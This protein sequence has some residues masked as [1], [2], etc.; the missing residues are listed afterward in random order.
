MLTNKLGSALF[1]YLQIIVFAFSM[2]L[3][4]LGQVNHD[5]IQLFFSL[6]LLFLANLAYGLEKMRERFVFFL[7]NFACIFFLYG[8]T[9]IRITEQDN[10]QG[11]YSTQAH[12]QTITMIYV[13][14][15]FLLFGAIFFGQFRN[16]KVNIKPVI[17][18]KRI[19]QTEEFIKNLQIITFIV[20][21]VLAVFMLLVEIEKP[22]RL[23]GAAYTEYYY[24]YQSSLPGIVISLAA[25]AKFALCL[26]LAT[27]PS[28][29][30][31]FIALGVYVAST[32]P[33][34]IVGQRNQFISA[35]L[36][37]VCYYLFRDCLALK[38]NK[39]RKQIKK[40]FGKF[41]GTAIAIAMPF[42]F[43]F[44]SI[45]ESIRLGLPVKSVKLFSSIS[46]LFYT[47]GI[48][49]DVICKCMEYLD[50]FPTTNISYTFG[51]IIN[52]FKGNVIGSF[53]GFEKPVSQTVESALY[54]NSLGDTI[55]YLDLGEQYLK[56]AGWGS[57]F[58]VEFFIDYGYVGVAI[59]S[60]VLGI[61]LMWVTKNFGK[62]CLKSYCILVL[63]IQLFMLPRSTS[64]GWIVL[65]I[66]IPAILMVVAIFAIT[67][68]MQKKYYK[69][70]R[71]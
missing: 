11:D 65:L 10:W 54:G 46:D 34:F 33:V 37:T 31:G 5:N 39:D 9:L 50:Q 51:Q 48:T 19:W 35:A 38:E 61:F 60:F 22:I 27:L 43:A 4:V 29:M 70:K 7:F 58:I 32:I 28:K 15:L 14:M 26:F 8:R 52:Y 63:M 16:K 17:V 71:G 18:R 55:S 53:L 64:T 57:S 40:W 49:Y 47:Q 41:E 66:Y 2:F 68:L 42:M 44:L 20:Y 24:N 30:F 45:Y 1:R 6:G 67:F 36:F 25:L 62:N 12:Y 56:G 23:K 59:L 69:D 13:S 3:F 21:M